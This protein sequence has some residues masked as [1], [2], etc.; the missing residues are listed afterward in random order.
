MPLQI[1]KQGNAIVAWDKGV[2]HHLYEDRFRLLGPDNPLVA[3]TGRGYV[4]AVFD[5]ISSLPMGL[6]AAQHMADRLLDYYQRPED[7]EAGF[8]GISIL[9]EEASE[10]IAGWGTWKD[11]RHDPVGGCA[12]VVALVEGEAVSIFQTADCEA[13]MLDRTKTWRALSP[14]VENTHVVSNYFGVPWKKGFELHS[15]FSE[16]KPGMRLLLFSDGL[17]KYG[18][19]PHVRSAAAERD[20]VGAI[21]RLHGRTCRNGAPDD[22]TVLVVDA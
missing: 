19:R 17:A 6:N 3:G 15:E 4:Y 5:G 20:V 13:W 14:L 11:E 1:E 12:G 22:W 9:L 2:T 18:A 21:Q 16:F 10:E 8:V 7:Y